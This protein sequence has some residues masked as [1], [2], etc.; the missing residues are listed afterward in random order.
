MSAA[1]SSPTAP[2]APGDRAT[3]P[4]T[5]PLRRLWRLADPDRARLALA[6]LLA[7][8]SLG[9]GV[10]L[11]A[12]SAWLISRASE[13]P[14][15]L[16]LQV[17]IV[18]VRAFG[19]FRGVF[20]YAERLVGHD[21]A[22][23]SLTRIRVGVYDRLERL[24][25]A[26]LGAY[27]QGDLM[28]RLVGDVDSSVDLIVRVVLPVISGLLAGGLAV[29]IGAA[30][31]PS[32]GLALLA[33]VI[34]VGVLSPWLTG[35]IGAQAQQSRAAAE[36]RLSA[37]VVTSLSAAPEL[38]AYGAVDAAVAGI[39]RADAELTAL[40][41]RSAT[42]SGLGG[43]LGALAT[44]L[45]V[46]ACIAL[47]VTAV[48]DGQVDGV[49]LATLVLLPLAIADVLS[50]MPAAALATAHVTGA[51]ERIFEVI[52]AP[53]PVPAGAHTDMASRP[54]DA[55]PGPAPASAAQANAPARPDAP[56]D[57]P[58][59][60]E[61]PAPTSAAPADAPRGGSGTAAASLTL[62]G[63]AARYPLAD[64]DAVSGIDLDLPPRR[65]IALVGP[66]G[67]GKSTIA[68]ILLRLLDHRTG[69]YQLAG[70]DVRDLGE[71]GVR[72]AMVAVDQKAHLFDTTIEANL[73][74]AN[75]EADAAQMRLA[76]E[77]A[78]LDGWI[79]SLPAGMATRVGA[80][81]SAVSGG[82]AQRIALARVLLA[83]RPIVVL[84]EPGEHLDPD[85]ADQVTAA[86]LSST[87]G[88]S[89]VL[90][91]HRMAHTGDCDE[92]VVLSQGQVVQRG[93][94]E[95]LAR[96]EGWYAEAAAREE[97]SPL[98]PKEPTDG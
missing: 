17:A 67:S 72:E 24:S 51:A 36:G 47:G 32:A 9:C 89:V 11:L 25:P 23:R 45:T 64:S 10:G 66:S 20:R 4:T 79:D 61:A 38:L 58:A 42:A 6:A 81:G 88:R 18:S 97:G 27:R 54:P 60:P 3:T 50:G 65:R 94:P 7:T 62:M 19:I 40:D 21:A 98:D 70:Q 41:R 16:F 85:M 15:I 2:S 86:A 92:V 29:A 95:E 13:Q 74:L 37:Q 49:W 83:D 78:Q 75:P 87:A 30:I 73:R 34:V 53:D 57:T 43:A 1:T 44:G 33:M 82:Q 76:V 59:Q 39:A 22:F 55:I 28:A 91:T 12:V 14:P 56:A 90:I 71:D 77:G 52:D 68:A 63:V 46:V 69:S 35:R 80:H 48:G 8:L 84:D 5:A 31:V 93:T 26:G 96:A